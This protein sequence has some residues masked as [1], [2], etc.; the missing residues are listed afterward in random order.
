MKCK[1][2]GTSSKA[3]E[4]CKIGVIVDVG[5]G[6]I[7]VRCGNETIAVTY[8]DFRDSW[9]FVYDKTDLKEKGICVNWSETLASSNES[10]LLARA[11]GRVCFG[12]ELAQ[13]WI[14]KQGPLPL[15][16]IHT[17]PTKKLFVE[18]HSIPE[19]SLFLLP[20]SSGYA[21]QNSNSK[22]EFKIAR[23]WVH[24]VTPDGNMT[25]Q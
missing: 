10:V 6:A 15:L 9:Q 16:T 4:V 11:W 13:Q 25:C 19:R 14:S 17:K 5:Q 8:V 22:S 21:F 12:L 2:S 20:H 23:D 18:E 24:Y 7:R 3:A 1:T